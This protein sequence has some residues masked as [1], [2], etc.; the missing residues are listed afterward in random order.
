MSYTT[1][2]F[3]FR[4]DVGPSGT[5]P[6]TQSASGGFSSYGPSIIPGSPG[7]PSQYM[8]E[9]FH[10]QSSSTTPEASPFDAPTYLGIEVSSVLSTLIYTGIAICSGPAPTPNPVFSPNWSVDPADLTVLKSWLISSGTIATWVPVTA[11]TYYYLVVE[12]YGAV[13]QHMSVQALARTADLFFQTKYLSGLESIFPIGQAFTL[14]G[15]VDAAGPFDLDVDWG[16]GNTTHRSYA[17][18]G[19]GTVV[20][21]LFIEFSGASLSGLGAPVTH[22]YDAA[23]LYTIT[24]TVTDA[25]GGVSAPTSLVAAVGPP[26]VDLVLTPSVLGT[27]PGTVVPT[28]T[29]HSDAWELMRGNAP[30]DNPD[31]YDPTASLHT[32]RPR[33]SW[34]LEVQ[35]G[36]AYGSDHVTTARWTGPGEPVNDPTPASPPPDALWFPDDFGNTNLRDNRLPARIQGF[37]TDFFETW[38]QQAFINVDLPFQALPQRQ[39]PRDDG[40]AISQRRSWPPPTTKQ[41]GLRRG[42]VSTVE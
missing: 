38:N 16:D 6:F 4:W 39:F 32:S 26:T 9:S 8:I 23:G 20:D 14:D 11:G 22:V 5:T 3:P 1:I 25:N 30:A 18:S 33:T 13:A 29:G 34:T 31:A 27:L 21:D 40:L 17:H 7:A 42:A 12:V 37:L 35:T 19:L 24:A 15:N 36:D 28:F 41:Y 2:G 10:D